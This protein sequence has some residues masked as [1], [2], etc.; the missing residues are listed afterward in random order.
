M[1][2]EAEEDFGEIVADTQVIPS[3]DD[4]HVEEVD[5]SPLVTDLK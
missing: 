1:M 3:V 5:Q 4:S 2:M